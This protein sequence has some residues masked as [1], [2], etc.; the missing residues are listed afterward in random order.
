[1]LGDPQQ[2]PERNY[3]R[4][5]QRMSKLVYRSQIVR[6]VF[7]EKVAHVFMSMMKVDGP[8]AHRV[9]RSPKTKLRR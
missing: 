9:L 8:V 7:G 3:V 2:S 1:M 4:R 5:D 6:D